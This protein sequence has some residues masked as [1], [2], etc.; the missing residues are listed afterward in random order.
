MTEQHA[1]TGLPPP[2][3]V[4]HHDWL[5]ADY[6]ADWID[7]DVTRD[8]TRRPTLLRMARWLAERDDQPVRVLDVGGGY[9]ALSSA[10]LD[11]LPRATV[12]LQDYSPAMLAQ[13][14][15][16]LAGYGDRVRFHVADLTDPAWTQGLDG[17]FDAV[18]SALA[19]HNLFD[20]D[21]IARVYRDV[22][23]LVRPGGV[24]LNSDLVHPTGPLLVELYHRDSSG[25]GDR[26]PRLA[27]AGGLVD[28]LR[29]L[30]DAGFDEVDC[31]LKELHHAVLVGLRAS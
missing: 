10:V 2:D 29:W 30:G 11:A 9:G 8:E 5:S 4:G 25:A 27:R 26:G 19:I 22:C 24:F 28:Q 6:V 7:R 1:D 12:V 3:Q 18:V 21:A 13:A 17:P 23:S 15:S 16:R 14:E 20:A 31:A